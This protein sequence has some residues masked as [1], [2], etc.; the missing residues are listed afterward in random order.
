MLRALR[1]DFGL[2]FSSD[3]L[4]LRAYAASQERVLTNFDGFAVRCSTLE[5]YQGLSIVN[6]YI[7]FEQSNSTL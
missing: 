1:C 4:G 7:D 2:I 6:L 3:G 5:I